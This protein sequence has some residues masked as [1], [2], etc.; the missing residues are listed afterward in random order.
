MK[1]ILCLL[2]SIITLCINTSAIEE[3]TT[4]KN[5]DTSNQSPRVI[6]LPEIVIPYKEIEILCKVVYGESRGLSEPEQRATIECVLNMVDA[7]NSTIEKTVTKNRYSGYYK[8]LSE[9]K[10]SKYKPMVEDE[11]YHYYLSKAMGIDNYD[12]YRYI[13]A[14][15]LYWMG[16][17]KTNYFCNVYHYGKLEIAKAN[18]WSFN[19]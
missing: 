16:D 8:N 5:I 4:N 14:D 17:G 11:L 19:D 3:I 1:K 12:N 18:A 9:T 13:P 7:R 15:Y 10:W 2:L 6:E